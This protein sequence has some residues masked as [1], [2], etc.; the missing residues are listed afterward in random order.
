MKNLKFSKD[1]RRYKPLAYKGEK[2]LDWA[3]NWTE[4]NELKIGSELLKYAME[5]QGLESW[6]ERSDRPQNI[7]PSSR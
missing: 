7:L 2:S 6:S 4:T 3:H 5:T 1:S